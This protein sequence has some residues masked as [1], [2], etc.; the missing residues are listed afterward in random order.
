MNSAFL[1]GDE[2][3]RDGGGN[4]NFVFLLCEEEGG[5]G[6]DL[7]FVFLLGEEKKRKRGGERGG[8]MIWIY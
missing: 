1:L 5:G 3:D 7:G 4:L 2:E 6:G 8:M